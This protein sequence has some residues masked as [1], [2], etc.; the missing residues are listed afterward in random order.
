MKFPFPYAETPEK[1]P[2]LIRFQSVKRERCTLCAVEQ[3]QRERV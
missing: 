3:Q 2:F 1:R